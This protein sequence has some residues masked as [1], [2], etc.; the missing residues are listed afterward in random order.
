MKIT[1]LI[2]KKIIDI[3]LGE[4]TVLISENNSGKRKIVSLH[5]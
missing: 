5:N 1:R 4:T 2:I 3:W